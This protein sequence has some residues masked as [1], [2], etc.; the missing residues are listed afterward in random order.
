MRTEP[1]RRSLLILA[2][3]FFLAPALSGA[4]EIRSFDVE[5]RV[6]REEPFT[7]TEQIAYDFGAENKHG[8][9]RLVPLR[10]TRSFGPDDRIGVEVVEVTDEAGRE[11]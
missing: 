7:V 9:Y 5:V 6:G 8:I 2:L 11:R 10:Y 3:L 4:E 1:A